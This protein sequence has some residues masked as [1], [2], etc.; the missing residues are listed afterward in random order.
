MQLVLPL[1]AARQDSRE[2]S[3]WC[4]PMRNEERKSSNAWV[5]ETMYKTNK[6][7]SNTRGKTSHGEITCAGGLILQYSLCP[8]IGIFLV[9]CVFIADSEQWAS[10]M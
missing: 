7:R 4:E 3:E 10:S 8:S 1:R 5:Q 6:L 2:N 9:A